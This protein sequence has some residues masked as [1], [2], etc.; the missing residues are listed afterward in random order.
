MREGGIG[1]RHFGAAVAGGGHRVRFRR[2]GG[3]LGD[4]CN[5]AHFDICDW[6]HV[7]VCVGEIGWRLRMQEIGLLVAEGVWEFWWGSTQSRY[8]LGKA[9]CSFLVSFSDCLQEC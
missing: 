6:H 4:G 8:R 9:L 1:Q 7:G 3:W 2:F 5:R